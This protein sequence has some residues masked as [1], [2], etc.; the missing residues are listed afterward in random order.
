[1]QDGAI[2][3]ASVS[4][5][6]EAQLFVKANPEGVGFYKRP[7]LN[8]KASSGAA[9]FSNP[10][11]RTTMIR[12]RVARIYMPQRKHVHC[13]PTNKTPGNYWAIEFSTIGIHKSPLMG[14]KSG[15]QDIMGNVAISFGRLNDA[16]AYAESKGW[17]YDVTYPNHSNRWHVKKNYTD[18]FKFKGEPKPVES[19]D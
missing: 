7:E 12:N 19:Y 17:G 3:R 6:R 13:H 8:T 2:Q 16:I 18:N 5:N 14:W 11:D 10:W 15:T 9:Y 1:M 4:N